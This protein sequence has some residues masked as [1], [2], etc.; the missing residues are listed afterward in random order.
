MIRGNRHF[1]RSNKVK[2]VTFHLVSLF[3]G[4]GEI[5]NGNLVFDEMFTTR[6]GIFGSDFDPGLHLLV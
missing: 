5:V 6:G 3:F 2:P 4:T 1:G